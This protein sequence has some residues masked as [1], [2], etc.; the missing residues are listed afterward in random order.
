MERSWNRFRN[1]PKGTEFL[2]SECESKHKLCDEI[3]VG[4]AEDLA[5]T[6]HDLQSAAVILDVQLPRDQREKDDDVIGGDGA[7]SDQDGIDLRFTEHRKDTCS[8]D[9]YSLP[10]DVSAHRML[11]QNF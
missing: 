3:A 2:E 6:I 5:Q 11:V 8:L 7:E 4:G 10:S 9:S 1:S